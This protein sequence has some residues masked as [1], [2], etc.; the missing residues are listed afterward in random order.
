MNSNIRSKPTEFIAAWGWILMPVVSRRL[1]HYAG[2]ST[3]LL[4]STPILR[5]NIL[6]EVRIFQLSPHS[7]SLT[8]ELETN[9]GPTAQHSASLTTILD[10]RL[11]VF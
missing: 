3:I 6:G 7:T 4:S 2:N 11:N 9:P 5:E 8:R 1:E 10:R